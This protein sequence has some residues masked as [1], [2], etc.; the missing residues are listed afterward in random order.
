MVIALAALL[1]EAAYCGVVIGFI[2]DD[3]A[4]NASCTRNRACPAWFIRPVWLVSIIC[5]SISVVLWLLLYLCLAGTP[6]EGVFP[7]VDQRGW[8]VGWHRSCQARLNIWWLLAQFFGYFSFG[9]LL[10]QTGLVFFTLENSVYL[11]SL[12][13]WT[14]QS[15]IVIMWV[16]RL[17]ILRMCVFLV[18]SHMLQ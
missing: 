7:H 11:A 15:Y 3:Q 18:H 16:S 2:A 14:I 6:F 10:T 17:C 4:Q 1:T 12:I 8:K 13:I 9:I 5:A